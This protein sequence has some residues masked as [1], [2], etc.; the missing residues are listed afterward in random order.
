[1][2]FCIRRKVD[3]FQPSIA[4]LLDFLFLEFKKA[5]G[6]GYSSMNTIRSAISAVATIDGTPAGQHPLVRRFMKA[7]FQ[8]RPSFPR[9]HSTWDPDVVLRHIRGLGPNSNLSLLQLSRKLVMLMLL[10]SGQRGQTLH[11]LD[12]QNMTVSDTKVSFRIGDLL[13]TS[14]PGNHLSELVFE[15]YEP[16]KFLCVYTAMRSYL[17]RTRETRG[18]TTRFFVTTKN[19]V[20]LASRD[21][22]RRWTRDIMREAGIDLAIFSPHSTRSASSSKASLTLPVSLILATVGWSSESVFAKYYK[23]PLCSQ[24]RFAHAVLA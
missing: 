13:K 22:L 16:D 4:F 7:V 6:R 15:A 1:M 23:K 5:K 8:E 24:H 20:T 12:I 19:P 17:D 14:R 11:L 3:P 18:S 2:S 9:L 21:T 10:V